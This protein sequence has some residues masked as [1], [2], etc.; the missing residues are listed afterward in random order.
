MSTSEAWKTQRDVATVPVTNEKMADFSYV[1]VF[2]HSLIVAGWRR[3]FL[4]LQGDKQDARLSDAGSVPRGPGW[5][6]GA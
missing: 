6:G 1:W 3:P 2:N 5:Y 4:R